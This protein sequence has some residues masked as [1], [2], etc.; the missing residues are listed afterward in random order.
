MLTCCFESL[1]APAVTEVKPC[2]AVQRR[3][4]QNKSRYA[5]MQL[6]GSRHS[7][8]VL[9]SA[10]RQAT[11]PASHHQSLPPCTALSHGRHRPWLK[12]LYPLQQCLSCPPFKPVGLHAGHALHAL[13][14]EAGLATRPASAAQTPRTHWPCRAGLGWAGL[15]WSGMACVCLWSEKPAMARPESNCQE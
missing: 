8:R 13:H 2:C 3:D 4:A 9:T 12:R 10:P 15:G 6:R 11:L 7:R 14:A 5:I 1:R